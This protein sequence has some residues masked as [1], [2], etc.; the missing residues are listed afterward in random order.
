MLQ[1]KLYFHEWHYSNRQSLGDFF[2]Y[3]NKIFAWWNKKQTHNSEFSR[4]AKGAAAL[5]MVRARFLPHRRHLF[6]ESSY[7]GGGS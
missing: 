1:L 2:C 7:G 4:L 3:Y 6:T 5:C